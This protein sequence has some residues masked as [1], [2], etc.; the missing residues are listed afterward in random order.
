[1]QESTLT[2]LIE[3]GYAPKDIIPLLNEED[4]RVFHK[5]LDTRKKAQ[6]AEELDR[7]RNRLRYYKPNKKQM[8]F[9]ELGAKFKERLF[10]AMNQGGKTYSG[11]AEL[12]MHATGRYPDWWTGRRYNKPVKIICGSESILLGMNGIQRLLVGEPQDESAW[13]TGFLPYDTI[14]SYSRGQVKNSLDAIVVRHVS[15]TNS[16]IRFASYDQGRSKWQADTVDLVWFD[17]EP[18]MDVYMEGITRTNATDGDIFITFTP[19]NGM[20]DVVKRFYPEPHP[21]IAHRCVRINMGIDDIDHYTEAKKKELLLTYPPHERQ[22]RMYGIPVFGSGMVFPIE[23]DDVIVN[24]FPIPDHFALMGA[25]DIGWDHPTAVVKIAWDRDNDVI[26]ATACYREKNKT[27]ALVAA[28]VKP[29]GNIEY[30]YPHD[31]LQHDKGSGKQ[32]AQFYREAGLNM[33]HHHAQYDDGSNSLEAS[34][35][36]MLERF[37][38]GRLK[39]FSSLGPLIE[40]LRNYHRKDGQI[41]KMDDDAISALRYA[42]MM[43]R[44]ARPKKSVEKSWLN[45][46]YKKKR[47]NNNSRSRA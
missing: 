3:Q 44:Y 43:K 25:I 19:L 30:A 6:E 37:Q 8:Q 17:E 47:Q 35:L 9:H 15:G 26:Y 5:L 45:D 23:L 29:W 34:V 32:I 12:A 39:I 31:A 33:T 2:R 42:I 13:G 20:T 10:M 27:P 40:E 21:S 18:P 38:T 24:P 1:M 4:R 14:I 11:A 46:Y 41:V 7:R 28:A 16:V 36:E 22:A